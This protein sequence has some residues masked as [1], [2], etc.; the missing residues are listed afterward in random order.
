MSVRVVTLPVGLGPADAIGFARRAKACGAS[1]LEVRDDFTQTLDAEALSTVLPLL[2]AFREGGGFTDVA[3]RLA[4]WHDRPFVP[5]QSPAGAAGPAVILSHHA[6]FALSSE[7]ADSLWASAGGGAALIKHVE[8]L[9]APETGA[10]LLET[11]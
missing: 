11:Q 7:A 4:R 1:V 8:P 6:Q 9:G 5:D 3:R 2:L 10:R